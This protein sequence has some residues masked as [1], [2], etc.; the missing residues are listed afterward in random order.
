MPNIFKKLKQYAL[1]ILFLLM[2][3]N[4]N[5]IYPYFNSMKSSLDSQ[6]N[7]LPSFRNQ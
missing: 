4:N 2:L 1:L 6:H 7:Q 3:I 5:D